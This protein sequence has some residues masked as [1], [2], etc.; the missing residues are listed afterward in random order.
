MTT[1]TYQPR[2]HTGISYSTINISP[3]MAREMLVKSADF[4]NRSLKNWRIDS[5]AADM[6]AGRW[7]ANG[8][9]L[10]FDKDGILLDGQHRLHA[11]IKAGVPVVMGVCFGVDRDTA[12]TIDQG[13]SRTMKDA[14]TMDGAKN[15]AAVMATARALHILRGNVDPECQ[16]GRRH[17]KNACLSTAGGMEQFLLANQG[18]EDA[19]AMVPSE[20]AKVVAATTLAA[21][22][23]EMSLVESQEAALDFVSGIAGDG[24]SKNDPRVVLRDR[25]IDDR[26][27]I[28]RGAGRTRIVA[29]NKVQQLA[30][31]VMAW[32]AWMH[33]ATVS[34]KF[35][36]LKDRSYPIP[37]PLTRKQAD[38]FGSAAARSGGRVSGYS[39]GSLADWRMQYG[40]E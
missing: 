18:I 4:Q 22:M 20:P 33:D 26:L 38:R 9:V 36:I 27:A 40:Q 12:Q 29:R 15:V 6:A 14:L 5:Y 39:R 3:E 1:N 32:N 7:R 19:W 35:L 28:A 21:M 25:F 2:K 24:L 17:D 30:L 16:T 10:V 23:L 34:A 31:L 8:E 11:I 13:C 37:V